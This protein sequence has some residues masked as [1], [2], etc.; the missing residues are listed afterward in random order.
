M[1]FRTICCLDDHSE[2]YGTWATSSMNAVV[3]N[4]A[5]RSHTQGGAL[6]TPANSEMQL[7]PFTLSRVATRTSLTKGEELKFMVTCAGIINMILNLSN[8]R[9]MNTVLSR[10]YKSYLL[11]LLCFCFRRTRAK[12][13]ETLPQSVLSHGICQHRHQEIIDPNQRHQLMK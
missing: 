11:A 10:E 8:A 1:S 5:A 6:L 9:N 12:R 7:F 4:A 2:V 3:S 13:A